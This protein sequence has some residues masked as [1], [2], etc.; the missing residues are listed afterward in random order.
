MTTDTLNGTATPPRDK[1]TN[2]AKPETNAENEPVKTIYIDAKNIWITDDGLL[3]DEGILFGLA[4]ADTTDK[5]AAIRNYY[6]DLKATTEAR[7]QTAGTTLAALL[8]DKKSLETELE[9]AYQK[10]VVKADTIQKPV[11][12]LFRNLLGLFLISGAAVGNF[13]L[14]HFFVTPAFGIATSFGVFLFGLFSLVAPISTWLQAEAE[15]NP[16]FFNRLRNGLLEIGA[17]IATTLFV[18][19]L[20]YDQ[21]AKW[22]L[23]IVTGLFLL[24]LFFFCGKLLLGVFHRLM[25]DIKTIRMYKDGIN[26]S[27]TIV[28]HNNKT[29]SELQSD[30]SNKTAAIE[31]L[32]KERTT[33][34]SAIHSLAEQANLKVNLFMS[35]YN[36]AKHFSNNNIV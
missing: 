16:S 17:P 22:G 5:V 23:T 10:Q 34:S 33:L 31:A 36:L 29:I 25:E 26:K 12:H 9:K 4:S 32:Q 14:I 7:L 24:F 18:S 27:Q 8:A 19:Y 1:E 35:E 2:K 28:D 15:T 13:F 3:R 11:T 20:V 30:I 6:N 21:T